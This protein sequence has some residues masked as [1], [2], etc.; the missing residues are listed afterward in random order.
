MSHQL[1]ILHLTK[2]F[3][4]NKKRYNKKAELKCA[5]GWAPI[6]YLV[7]WSY[8]LNV[9]GLVPGAGRYRPGAWA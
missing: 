2:T 1:S 9:F 8:N 5:I 6:L 7:S 3:F 4:R